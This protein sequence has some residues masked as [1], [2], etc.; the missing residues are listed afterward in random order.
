MKPVQKLVGKPVQNHCR[1]HHVEVEQSVD[2]QLPDEREGIVHVPVEQFV[3]VPVLLLQ[4]EI[5]P[6]PA[7]V[8]PQNPLLQPVGVLVDVLL[9]EDGGPIVAERGAHAHPR[10]PRC[11]RRGPSLP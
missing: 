9:R 8:R 3:E 2:I 5:A 1:H 7:P 4:E 11:P 10:P 6:V